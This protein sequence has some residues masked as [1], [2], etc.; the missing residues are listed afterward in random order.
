MSF[1]S[2]R[3]TFLHCINSYCVA[4]HFLFNLKTN[5]AA[6]SRWRTNVVDKDNH[7]HMSLINKLSSLNCHC[8]LHSSKILLPAC[9]NFWL[10]MQQP[11][12]PNSLTLRVCF[13]PILFWWLP[14]SPQN[15]MIATTTDFLPSTSYWIKDDDHN[16]DDIDHVWWL[17]CHDSRCRTCF[18]KCVAQS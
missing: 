5:K 11:L 17:R 16:D 4:C 9:S 13:S 15:S 10:F 6:V 7:S 18:L 3:S 8:F 2:E 1:H 12:M 14:R